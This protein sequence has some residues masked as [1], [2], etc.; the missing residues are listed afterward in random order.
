M[1][2]CFFDTSALI[3]YYHAEAGR[4]KVIVLVE[5]PASN[6]Q[7]SRL[8]Y[9]E[10]HSAFARRVRTGEISS[11]E[12]RSLRGRFY[13]DLRDRK[14]RVIPLR[15]IHL[16]RAARLLSNHGLTHSLRTLDALQLTVALDLSRL[17][18][19][20]AFVCADANLCHVA[21]LEGLSIINP[22]VD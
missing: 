21:R 14:F 11:D 8:S 15:A 12:F 22:E 13:A 2:V 7:I 6:I 1:A 9:V 5:E 19:L 18:P 16:Q 10:W 17:A 4:Q 20:D 3:K